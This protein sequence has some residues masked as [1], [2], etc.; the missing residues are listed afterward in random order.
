MYGN[1]GGAGSIRAET[2]AIGLSADGI[3]V[4]DS[5][6]DSGGDVVTDP[7]AILPQKSVRL[8]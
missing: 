7:N 2:T 4:Y 5:G 6:G 1:F 3:D 8:V